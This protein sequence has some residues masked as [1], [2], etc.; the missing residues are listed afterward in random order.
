[1]CDL[2]KA[3]DVINHDILIKN[4]LNYLTDRKQYVEIENT[5][6]G[7]QNIM[8]EVPQGSILVRLLYLIYVNDISKSTNGHILS[9]ADDSSVYIFDSDLDE[10]FNQANSKFAE[11]F[12]W[13]C[14]N[15]LSLNPTKTKYIVF[16]P[17]SKKCDFLGKVGTKLNQIG[18]NFNDQTTQF[19]GI[20]IYG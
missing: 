4:F 1:M 13:F 11:L 3:F 5:K 10:L 6:S 16:R 19:L 12:D 9:F 18:A 17:R 8:C 15:L 20:Y 7:F 14:A 2:S